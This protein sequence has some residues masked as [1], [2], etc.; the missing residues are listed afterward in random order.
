M[1]HWSLEI[2]W[3]P[4]RMG[5]SIKLNSR[6]KMKRNGHIQTYTKHTYESFSC[7]SVHII[8]EK[9]RCERDTRAWN[10]STWLSIEHQCMPMI[11]TMHVKALTEWRRK[12]RIC[13]EPNERWRQNM[14]LGLNGNSMGKIQTQRTKLNTNKRN[15]RCRGDKESHRVNSKNI[16]SVWSDES[17][18][19]QLC[20][21]CAQFA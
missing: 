13:D 10:V 21:N 11:W 7:C 16:P 15:K 4:H 1:V 9:N 19:I 3:H 17:E 6:L 18:W 2:I 20:S 12:Y 14:Q 8:T 5:S